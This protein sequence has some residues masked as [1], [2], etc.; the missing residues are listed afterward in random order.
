MYCENRHKNCSGRVALRVIICVVSLLLAGAA[1]A[2]ALRAFEHKKADDY[3][4]A[5]AISE[6][7][8]QAAFE[9]IAKTPDWSAG[10]SKE[11]YEGGSFDVELERQ[12]RDGMVYLKIKST[13]VIGSVIQTK[14][15][16]LRLEMSETDSIWVNES[17]R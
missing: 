8:L 13:G 12:T 16:T 7:G 1:I 5:L 17:M 3:R 14:E 2:A 4:K 15:C 9:M 11:P 10:F 6:Y